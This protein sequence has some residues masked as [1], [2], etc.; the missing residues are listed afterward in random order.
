M[1]IHGIARLYPGLSP[2]D[3]LQQD[4]DFWIRHVLIL[5]EAG[6]IDGG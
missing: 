5:K 6:V 2:L 4:A 1:T 3:V